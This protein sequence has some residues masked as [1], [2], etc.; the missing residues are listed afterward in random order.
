MA[1]HLLPGEDASSRWFEYYASIFDTVELNATFYRLPKRETV[2]SWAEQ[3]PDGF[4]FAV[5][6]SRY[7][8]HMRRLRD[9]ATGLSRFWEP[10]EPL[11]EAGKLGPILWQLPESFQ[12]DDEILATALAA[13]PRARHCFEFR[14]PSWFKPSVYELLEAHGASLVLGDDRRRPLPEASPVGP[15]AYLRLHF[16]SRGRQG[17]YSDAEL[18]TWRRRIAAWRAR[19]EVFV[20]L[21]NDWQTF[22]PRNA[23]KLRRGLS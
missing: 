5:K 8:T 20:Y 16:G 12:R 7:L 23:L 19:R 6:G 10:L 14:H 17:N 22:A 1:R 2:A 15:I 18:E 4:L 3:A 9:L 13:M 21:N 11:R